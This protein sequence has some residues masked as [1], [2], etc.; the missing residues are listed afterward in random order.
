MG[1]FIKLMLTVAVVMR[2]VSPVY[3]MDKT[4]TIFMCGDIMTGRGIDQVLPHPSDP[5]LHED[6]VKDAR[7]YVGLAES[8]HG[9]IP[10]PVAYSYIWGDALDVFERISPDI[11]LINL[12]TAVTASDDWWKAK[13]INYRMNPENIR[14]LTAAGIDAASLANNHVLDWGYDGLADTT[15]ALKNAG[16]AFSG[17]GS[18]IAE[19]AAPIIRPVPGKGRVIVFS[20]AARSSGVPLS[21]EAAPGKPGVN[22]LKDLSPV[23]AAGITARI[24]AF[25]KKGDIVIVSIHWG[26]NWG[27]D[28]PEEQQTFAH[29]LTG[30]A[31]ADIIC[32]HSSHHFK[33]IEIFNGRLILYG[34]GD[35]INDYEGIGGYES[36]RDNLRL[37]YFA[38]MDPSGGLR[39]LQLVPMKMSRFRLGRASRQDSQWITGV[40]NREGAGFGT[41]FEIAADNSISFIK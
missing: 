14:V 9:N 21:W 22:L 13:G 12:E 30:D 1:M 39:T 33:G 27:Y 7:R 10:A 3:A 36:F 19:A 25:K 38:G 24:H 16:I 37:M 32:G 8:V 31:A 29:A 20:Y 41:H 2:T 35:F 15:R 26:G 18:N 6:Y 28:I 23:T 34:C 5:L 11:R 40:L 17:A 4:I